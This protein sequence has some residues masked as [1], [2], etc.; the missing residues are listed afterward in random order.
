MDAF[1]TLEPNAL[2]S[3]ND[4]LQNPNGIG[5]A[6]GGLACISSAKTFSFS[7]ENLTGA[8]GGG[9]RAETG[10][11]AK[12]AG[13]LGTGWKIIPASTFPLEPLC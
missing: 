3:M 12:S 1:P 8:K 7:P 9:G 2:F 10:A 5:Q 4:N 11:G 13:P 6:F